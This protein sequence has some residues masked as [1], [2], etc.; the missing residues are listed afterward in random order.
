MKAAVYEKYG[1][2]EV[3]QIKEVPK[4]SP[5]SDEL[6]I[7]IHA[8]SVRAGDSRM[9]AFRVHALEWLPARL[10][11]GITK[12]KR[13]ILGME[14]A[15]EVEAGGSDVTRFQVG[16]KVYATTELDFGAHAEYTC[17]RES[18]IVAPMPANMSYE[19]AAA[20]PTGGLG[21]L[22]LVRQGRIQAGQKVLVYGA[23]GSVGTYALQLAKHL[24]A[25]VSGVC[26]FRH[27][28]MVAGLGADRVIDYTQEDFSEMG[29]R[30]DCILDAVGKTSRSRCGKALAPGGSFV[31][32]HKVNYK[33]TADD[34]VFL[35]GLIEAGEI[36]AAID[37]TYSLEEI[38][39][40]YRYVDE[41]HKAGN[42]VITVSG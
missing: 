34:L 4:P 41:G 1:P 19:Q 8:T 21:A 14:L 40:A 29:D 20:V 3:V 35:K 15:G 31:S 36:V 30:Y 7:K 18:R 12:P 42:V 9:R 23:S 13:S 24:G 11:L 39:E 17:L 37:R 10:Y 28:D 25:G 32:M 6:L 38:V 16:D 26:S 27:L 5:K 33:E 2:P 22:A